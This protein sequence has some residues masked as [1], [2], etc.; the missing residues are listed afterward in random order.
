MRL[1]YAL[2]NS[3]EKAMTIFEVRLYVVAF[4]PFIP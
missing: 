3:G 2:S 1:F 4:S